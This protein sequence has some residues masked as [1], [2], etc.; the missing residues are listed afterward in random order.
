M[1]NDSFAATPC[2]SAVGPVDALLRGI[3]ANGCLGLNRSPFFLFLA[4]S[5]PGLMIAAVQLLVRQVVFGRRSA[6]R[7]SLREIA[8]RARAERYAKEPL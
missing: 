4:I 2:T 3:P 7:L 6:P 5:G 8:N 1:L